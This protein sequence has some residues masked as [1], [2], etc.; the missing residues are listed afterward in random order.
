MPHFRQTARHSPR[1]PYFKNN[2]KIVKT[3]KNELDDDKE[4]FVKILQNIEKDVLENEQ[5]VKAALIHY[6]EGNNGQFSYCDI[7]A[8]R[9]DY[10]DIM[11]DSFDLNLLKKDTRMD[12]CSQ[13]NIWRSIDSM[14]NDK[15][16]QRYLSRLDYIKYNKDREIIREKINGINKVVEEIH[17]FSLGELIDIYGSDIIFSDEVQNNKFLIFLLSKGFINEDYADYINYF[18]PNSITKDEMNF[19]RKVRMQETGEDW[20]QTMKN[21]AQVCA[22]IEDYEFKQ[23][24]IL[25]FDI[26]D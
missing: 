24:Q 9:Y 16:I 2:K 3:K 14:K 25:N 21:V 10:Q 4:R 8:D 26:V 19:I 13:N 23:I 6:L 5:E 18:H 7:G 22:R 15:N 17:S 20:T 12:I 1:L 11:D